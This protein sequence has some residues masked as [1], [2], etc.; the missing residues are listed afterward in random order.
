MGLDRLRVLLLALASIALLVVSALLLDWFRMTLP[1]IELDLRT[2]RMCDLEGTCVAAPVG[3]TYGAFAMA[4]LWASLVFA[5]LVA[6]LG[7]VRALGGVL[8]EQLTRLGY[9]LGIGVFLAAF[10]TGYLFHPEISIKLGPIEIAFE[11]T[12]APS[13][14]LLGALLGVAALYYGLNPGDGGATTYVPVVVEGKRPDVESGLRVRI[15]TPPGTIA[16]S[17]TTS[18]PGAVTTGRI[19]TP[20]G[21]AGT[22]RIT[23]PPGMVALSRTPTPNTVATSRTPTPN[24]A[25]ATPRAQ[26]QTNIATSRTPTPNTIATSRA[27]TP[28]SIAKARTPT[29]DRPR[30][31]TPPGVETRRPITPPPGDIV[32]TR[33]KTPTSQPMPFPEGLRGKLAYAIASAEITS[34]G[35]DA[36]REGGE[37][38][39]VL[40]RDVVGVVARRLPQ[41]YDALTFADLVSTAGSTVRVLPWTRLTGQPLEGEDEDRM[42]AFIQLV[43]ERCPNAKIDGATRQFLDGYDAAQL[44]DAA[45]LKAHDERLA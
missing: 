40:W 43:A 44:P 21:V 41:F 27:P 12:L 33:R 7:G 22:G 11:R 18:P 26:T 24:T 2:A 1:S 36:R 38:V 39:L 8:N 23:T 16:Q 31:T 15:T 20:P 10:A 45:T 35:V 37:V 9:F 5:G 17:R 34:G 28:D 42:R 13:L 3:G 14:M 30:I 6:Y 25:V 29:P 19:T 4:T 32:I